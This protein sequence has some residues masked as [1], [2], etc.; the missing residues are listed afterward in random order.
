MLPTVTQELTDAQI[1]RFALR[2][3]ACV[4]ADSQDREASFWAHEIGLRGEAARRVLEACAELDD[5]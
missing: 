4:K 2:V 5:A 3:R 1:Q